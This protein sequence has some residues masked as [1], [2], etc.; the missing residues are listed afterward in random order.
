MIKGLKSVV[1][2]TAMNTEVRIG[3]YLAAL[4]CA[5]V[6]DLEEV[7]TQMLSEDNY[8]GGDSFI[9]LIINVQFSIN[10]F[11]CFFLILQILYPY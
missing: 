7:I 3:S 9:S 4:R 10:V 2:D 11:V 5:T 6:G 8:Q 1:L